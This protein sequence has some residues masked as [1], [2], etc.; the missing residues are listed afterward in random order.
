MKF[1]KII[2]LGSNSFTGSHFINHLLKNY[3]CEIVTISRSVEY[4][5]IFLPFLYKKE[6]PDYTFYQLDVNRNH[7]QICAICD[8]FEPEVIVNFSAQGEVR[9]SWKHPLQW[10]ETNCISVVRLTEHLK[11]KNT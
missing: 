2:I 9:N 11:K 5:P 7:D 1:K 4:D 6:K 10:Y 8:D 3:N